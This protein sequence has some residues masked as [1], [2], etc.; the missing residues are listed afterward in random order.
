VRQALTNGLALK[1]QTEQVIANID[2]VT[3]SLD[4][5][6]PQTYHTIRGVDALSVVLDGIKAVA[7]NVPVTTRTTVQR[8]N[9]REIPQVVDVAKNAGVSKVSFLA[10]DTSNQVAFGPRFTDE[11]HPPLPALTPHELPEFA[12][13][14]ADMEQSHAADFASGLIAES[15][16][17]LRQNRGGWNSASLFLPARYG[18]TCQQ[19]A[20]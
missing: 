1:K 19:I 7:C 16:A 3:V 14:L 13:I 11:H 4:A 17:R 12:A 18:Q 20:A 6:S 8:G 15:P 10:V 2:Q 5:A 9:F